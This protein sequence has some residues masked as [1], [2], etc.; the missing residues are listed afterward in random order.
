MLKTWSLIN[1]MIDRKI[2]EPIETKLQ[3]NFQTQDSKLLANNFNLN[4]ISQIKDIKDKN[5]GPVLDVHTVDH[6]LHCAKAT[7]Y[8]RKAKEKDVYDILKNMKKKG[9][10]IDGLRNSDIIRNI[11]ILTPIITYLVNLMMRNAEIPTALK[12]SCITPLFKN[13]GKPDVLGSYRPVGSMPIIEKVLEKHLNIQTKKYL[14]E[15]RIIPDFQHGFQ[16]GK[17]TMTLLQDFAEQINRALDQR[18][19]VVILLLDL[20]F[21]FD[22]IHHERL[23][24]KFK[25]IGMT[26]PVWKNYFEQRKQVTRIGS[27]ISTKLAVEQGLVQGGINSPTWYNVYTYDVKYVQRIGS[28]K[29]F[30]DDSCIISIHHDVQTA[31]ANAQ[32][33]FINLQKYLYNNHIYLNEKK[34]EALVLG[35]RSKRI[36]MNEHRIYC[37]TRQCLFDKTYETSCT[38]YQIEYKHEAKYLGVYIDSEFRMKSHVIH[39]CKKLR[40]LKYKLQ[41]V[42]ADKLPMT[43]KKTIYFS[44]VDSLLRY[45]VTLYMYATNHVLNPLYNLQRR[46]LSLLFKEVNVYSLNPEQLNKYVLLSTNFLNEKYRILNPQPYLLRNQSFRRPRVYTVQYGDRRLEFVIPSLLNTYCRDF[47]DEK[48]MILVKKKIKE[49]LLAY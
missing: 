24:R 35:Y 36:D 46:I 42:N 37:H 13:K 28:L 23:L 33:D 21:A 43:T 7:M 15:N 5:N 10:G 6:E 8:L 17:S 39:L 22:T 48:K 3:R 47:L 49:R 29:M 40:I 25:D 19:A 2:K 38:C 45:G 12:T 44:L 27:T 16:S 26:H 18:K 32:H 1:D 4:F 14:D 34:T 9:R 30:A 31:V 11:N 20:S 41:K